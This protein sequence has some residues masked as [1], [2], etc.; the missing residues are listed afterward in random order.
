MLRRSWSDR[1]AELLPPMTRQAIA[2][3]KGVRLSCSWLRLLEPR[4]AAPESGAGGEAWPQ[5]D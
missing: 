1:C 4:R 3:G 5:L 2:W